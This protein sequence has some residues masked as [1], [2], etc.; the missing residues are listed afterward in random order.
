M[1]SIEINI[2]DAVYFADNQY[3]SLEAPTT[4]AMNT[5]EQGTGAG[6][7]FLGWVKLPSETPQSHLD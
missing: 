3:V 2:Q 5:L 6:A 1:R 7:D 4:A